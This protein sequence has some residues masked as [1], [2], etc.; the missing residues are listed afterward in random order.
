M[1][2]AQPVIDPHH[3]LWDLGHNT[4][5]WLQAR[6]FKPRLEGDIRPIARLLNHATGAGAA[7]HYV[8]GRAGF[9]GDDPRKL[10]S[11]DG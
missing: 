2:D 5:P 10:P 1:P 9:G 11:S 6:F 7:Q 3:H 8:D 4:Y